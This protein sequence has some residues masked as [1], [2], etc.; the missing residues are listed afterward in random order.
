MHR[1]VPLDRFDGLPGMTN[2]LAA[3][4][5]D[6]QCARYGQN[7]IL[8]AA[9]G[10]W[11]WLLQETAKDPM[12]WFLVGTSGIFAFVGQWTESAVLLA[13]LVPFLGMDAYLNRRTQA[14]IEGLSDR[15][16]TQATVERDGCRRV[17]ASVALVPGD[18]V[19]I[20]AGDALPADG[21]FV[22]G[23]RVQVDESTLTGEAFPVRKEALAQFPRNDAGT[24]VDGRH[25]GFAGTRLLTGEALLRV[26][27]TG[28]ET[29][30][31][32]IVRS[33][34]RRA[35]DRTPLQDAVA[36]LVAVLVVGAGL[37]CL[38][39]AWVRIQQ[40]HG[41][42]DAL[43][44]AVTLAVAALP[45][46][47][48]VVL[49]FFL[50]VGVYRL[51]RKQALVRRAVVVEN[52]GRV[53]CICSD[54]TGTITEG[55]LQLTHRCPADG[56]SDERLLLL[57]AAASRRETGDPMDSAILDGLNQA[58]PWALLASFPFTEDRK[59]ETGIVRENGALLAAVKGAPEVVLAQCD[60]APADRARWLA[61]INKFAGTGHKVIACAWRALDG[62]VW[63]GGEPDRNF[64][65][66][67]LMCFEDPV[68]AGVREALQA[69]RRAG[70][71]VI[72]VTGDHPSTA[73]AVAREI[74]LG[75]GE[76]RIVEGDQVAARLAQGD[77]SS[78]LEVDVIA[79][80][81]PAQKL[82]LVR[83][84]QASGDIV[85][86]T[87]DGVNDVPALLAADIGIAMGERGTRSAR[88]VAA[89]V[90]L[91]DNFRSI[92]RAIAEGRQLFTNLQL[93]FQ[94]LLMIHLPLVA[95]AALIPLAG[96]P[97]LYLPIHVVWLELIIHP[98]ALLVFQEMPGDH[99][100]LPARRNARLRFFSR[101]QWLMIVGVGILVTAVVAASYLHSLGAG[102]NV[103]HARAMAMVALT[104][105]SAGIT[106]SLSQL[107][108]HAARI[109][110]AGTMALSF[111]LV[112]T[113][114][115][116][117]LLHLKPLHADD[118]ML[119]IGGGLLASLLSA[120]A[121]VRRR[122]NGNEP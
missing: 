5:V 33:A 48:P 53:S 108:S 93:S 14:S 107:R 117:M 1:S 66:A 63:P 57:A 9:P 19:V 4:Q 23:E 102:Y 104:T 34:T 60:L 79:R 105:A 38:V 118:W 6:A 28:S 59:R 74:G 45:E 122:P 96:Y 97:L 76:P 114:A 83:A 86:V 120:A 101:R 106:A 99:D 37:V 29:L 52:I 27:Y 89:I 72:M 17:I 91:D 68:R 43:L 98:T 47:F 44:S 31:G 87:G 103:E 100:L 21:L 80:A 112:Q 78:L 55:Q 49:T 51:A 42:L 7:L 71:R 58:P 20:G 30:Y 12:L 121:S 2:G 94:Y 24:R 81:V 82:D 109:V 35:R 84:L 67:G 10:G 88:E 61:Q 54:K 46:E 77:T 36:N 50:G 90:L 119:A 56:V 64:Q 70:I 92:V 62:A 85:A 113:P 110:V 16:A 25:W 75:P 116:A 3:H 8:D 95:T 22:R 32:E 41:L 18:L 26:A 69:C 11:I 73:R 40:G 111:L 115:L 65:L 15:L 39:L 13:A